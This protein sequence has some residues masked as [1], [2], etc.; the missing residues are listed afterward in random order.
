MRELSEHACTLVQNVNFLFSITYDRPNRESAP[1][2][3]VIAVGSSVYFWST[4]LHRSLAPPP[5]KSVPKR[6]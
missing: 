3:A 5:H 1:V 6:G 2:A 4:I